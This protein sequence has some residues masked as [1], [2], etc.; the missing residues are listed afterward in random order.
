[1]RLFSYAEDDMV[2]IQLGHRNRRR[3]RRRADV[4]QELGTE[5]HLWGD[6]SG[7]RGEWDEQGFALYRLPKDQG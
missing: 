2:N 3:R 1:M 7:R 6:F 5:S 4:A